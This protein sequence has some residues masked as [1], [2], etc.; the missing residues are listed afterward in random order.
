MKKMD[1]KNMS[2]K[3]KQTAYNAY[4]EKYR[5]VEMDEIP[6]DPQMDYGTF[7]VYLE[8]EAKDNPNVSVNG[9]INNIVNGQKDILTPKQV[10]ALQRNASAIFEMYRSDAQIM[11]YLNDTGFMVF[12]DPVLQKYWGEH[13]GAGLTALLTS[14]QLE[15]WNSFYNS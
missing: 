8:A 9:A 10:A 6:L 3:Q 2:S 7:V 11:D 4:R 15:D 14:R 13:Y 12:T 1:F 5:A